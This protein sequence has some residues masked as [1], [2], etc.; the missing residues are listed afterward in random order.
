MTDLMLAA[1]LIRLHEA[2]RW[3]SRRVPADT[4]DVY[5]GGCIRRDEEG[6]EDDI[7]GWLAKTN[8]EQRRLS[9]CAASIGWAYSL[10]AENSMCSPPPWRAGALEM[11][12][13]GVRGRSWRV[14]SANE[15]KA[16]AELPRGCVAVY[17]RGK[18]ESGLGHV[19]TLD[20][21]D[22]DRFWSLGGNERGGRWYMDADDAPKTLDHKSL[23]CFL[24]LADDGNC[25]QL[26]QPEMV[27]APVEEFGDEDDLSELLGSIVLDPDWEAARNER[28]AQIA[29]D[30]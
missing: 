24:V 18:P 26:D 10:A 21:R 9:W 20:R 12:N 28:D 15:A 22:G 17:R 16:G 27:A 29:G 13:D 2:K 25:Q 6:N 4:T 11:R 30:S 1:H 23:V 3:G 5:F 14:V 19:E 8:T 7:G